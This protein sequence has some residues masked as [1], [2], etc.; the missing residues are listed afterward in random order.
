MS[1]YPAPELSNLPEDIRAKVLEVQAK[2][3]FVP[4][5][6]WP[7]RAGRPSGG[8]FLLTTTR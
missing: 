2:A 7:W 5:V 8:R 1:R 4:N 3:G 6:F